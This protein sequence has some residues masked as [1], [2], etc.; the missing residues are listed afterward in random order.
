MSSMTRNMQRVAIRSKRSSLA[1]KALAGRKFGTAL[2]VRNPK[3]PKPNS[4]IAR[5]HRRGTHKNPHR[6]AV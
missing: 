2:G 5:G 6:L 3:A 1:A 4:L